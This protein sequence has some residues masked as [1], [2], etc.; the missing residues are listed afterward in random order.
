MEY[1]KDE[2]KGP[3]VHRT[4]KRHAFARYEYYHHQTFML[5]RSRLFAMCV[6]W[7]LLLFLMLSPSSCYTAL[8]WRPHL[9][10]FYYFNPYIV[11]ALALFVY[12]VE[13]LLFAV[14]RSELFYRSAPMLQPSKWPR[15]HLP[16]CVSVCLFRLTMNLCLCFFH[17]K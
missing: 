12:F 6:C 14:V 7:L 15:L 5:G 10:P 11:A 8:P 4:H 1:Y 3:L 9:I 17:L 13:T 2:R 16:A